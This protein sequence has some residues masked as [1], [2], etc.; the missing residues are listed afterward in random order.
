MTENYYFIQNLAG[1]ITRLRKERGLKQEDLAKEIGV[2]K[3]SISNIEKQRAFPT[4]ANLDKMARFFKVTPNQLFGTSQELELEKA[5]YSTDEYDQRVKEILTQ[6]QTIQQVFN[7]EDFVNHLNQ[8]TMLLLP[9]EKIDNDGT[10]LYWKMDE[11]GI[12]NK[13]ILYREEQ[14]PMLGGDFTFAHEEE[15]PLDKLL[16][17]K[18]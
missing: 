15:T 18:K 16:K 14:L 1:N 7:D 8:M 6:I 2:S 11:H 4:L 17:I 3:N 13:N 9:K 12:P 10:P 5:A